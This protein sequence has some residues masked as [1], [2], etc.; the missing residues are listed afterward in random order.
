MKVTFT[1]SMNFPDDVL[2]PQQQEIFGAWVQDAAKKANYGINRKV[3][4]DAFMKATGGKLTPSAMTRPKSKIIQLEDL[5]K[6][7]N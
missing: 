4:D 7:T 3:I 1:I 6:R 5:N 2:T